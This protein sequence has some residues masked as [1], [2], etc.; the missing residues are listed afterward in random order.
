MSS[1]AL[2]P[3]RAALYLDLIRW[4]R[5]AGWLLLLW[6]TLSALSG[7]CGQQEVSGRMRGEPSWNRY[8]FHFKEPL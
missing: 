1:E 3:T 6:P 4:N 8:P 2:A 7:G 5:P